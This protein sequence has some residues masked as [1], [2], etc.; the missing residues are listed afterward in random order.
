MYKI[1]YTNEAK[2][3]VEK[4]SIKKKRQIKEA[5]E[6][7]A[8]DPNIGKHLIHE[9][10][11]LSSYHSGTGRIIYRIYRQEIV[12]LILTIGHRK[13][14]YKNIKRTKPRRF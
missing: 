14:V 2:T 1:L 7:I 8:E 10:K 9:L 5:V 6:H 13:N 12:V 4:L 3:S 11:G